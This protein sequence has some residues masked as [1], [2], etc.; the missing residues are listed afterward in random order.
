MT[1]IR[2]LIS[3]LLG[4]IISKHPSVIGRLSS[5]LRVI[6][7][8]CCHVEPLAIDGRRQAGEDTTKVDNGQC[9]P[10]AIHGARRAQCIDF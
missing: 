7:D 8:A 4:V 6:Q 1:Y 3:K 2:S 10:R 9:D 5:Q